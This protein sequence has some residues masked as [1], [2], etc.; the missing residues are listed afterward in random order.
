M[1]RQRNC[2]L[3]WSTAIFYCSLKRYFARIKAQRCDSIR[4][5]FGSNI[6]GHDAKT[7]VNRAAKESEWVWRIGATVLCALGAV[8]SGGAVE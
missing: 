7:R 4:N 8:G 6:E 5:G 2:G 1:N 3:L